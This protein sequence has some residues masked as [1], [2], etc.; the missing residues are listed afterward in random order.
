MILGADQALWLKKLDPDWD[1]IRS[2][3]DYFLSQPGRAEKVLRMGAS[4]DLFFF[5]RYHSYGFDAVSNA[6][7]GPDAVPDR[8]RAKALCRLGFRVFSAGFDQRTYGSEAAMQAGTAMMEEGLEMCRRVRDERLTAEVLVNLSRAAQDGE[9]AS[10]P[11]ATP[12]RR[13]RSAVAWLMTGSS[14][15]PS[16]LW[17]A[18]SAN[19]QKKRLLTEAVAHLRRTGDLVKWCGVW[20]IN[21]AALELADENSQAAAELLEEAL[22][23]SEGLNLPL[24][25]LTACCVLADITMF[26]SRFDEAAIWLRRALISSAVWPDTSR[27]S[28][29]F[30]MRSAAWPGWGTRATPP[31]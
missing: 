31:A 6:L 13:S 26:E 24:E 22:A 28:Q 19:G 25:L 4:L 7:A 29:T 23:I 18:P 21:L 8:V 9:M 16:G 15:M 20:L 5:A 12:R 1:N 3:L 2:A 17:A 11:Y 30:R 10:K 27:P 14:A